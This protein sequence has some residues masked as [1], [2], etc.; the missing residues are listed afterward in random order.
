M[1][2]GYGAAAELAALLPTDLFRQQG[3]GG[4]LLSALTSSQSSDTN[5]TTQRPAARRPATAFTDGG[6]SAE[7]DKREEDAEAD[8][9]QAS[10]DLVSYSSREHAIHAAWKHAQKADDM[11]KEAAEIALGASNEAME[12]RRALDQ[13]DIIGIESESQADVNKAGAADAVQEEAM[14]L[15]AAGLAVV[16][17][18]RRPPPPSKK[19]RLRTGDLASFLF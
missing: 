12:A 17:S 10:A 1:V 15:A 5:W 6:C 13:H 16:V 2:A 19:K 7:D 14:P 3:A 9:S 8:A 11:A 18:T 4:R